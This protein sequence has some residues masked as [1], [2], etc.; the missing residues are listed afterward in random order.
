MPGFGGI[1]KLQKGLTADIL[2]HFKNRENWR[3]Q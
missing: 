2:T 3:K 1:E